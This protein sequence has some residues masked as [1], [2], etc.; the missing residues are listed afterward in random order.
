[1]FTRIRIQEVWHATGYIAGVL[2]RTNVQYFDRTCV[3]IISADSSTQTAVNVDTL[4]VESTDPNGAVSRPDGTEITS[5]PQSGLEAM[6]LACDVVDSVA[7][8]KERPYNAHQS[9]PWLNLVGDRR[10]SPRQRNRR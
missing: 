10:Y 1:M 5:R 8:R 4:S 3:A 7:P 9:H 6:G 2:E